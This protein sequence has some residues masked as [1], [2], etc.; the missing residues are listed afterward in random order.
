MVKTR[1]SAER[2]AVQ[3]LLIEDDSATALKV[4]QIL[5]TARG[6][7]VEVDWCE[8]LGDGL[9]QLKDQAYDVILLD[10][11]LPDVDALDVVR[12]LLDA[13]PL[14]PV[15]VLSGEG[16]GD[17]ALQA[18]RH[19]ALDYIP[20]DR[21]DRVRLG[22]AIRHAIEHRRADATLRRQEARLAEVFAQLPQGIVVVDPGGRLRFANPL[23]QEYLAGLTPERVHE[24]D[25]L[26]A[27]GGMSLGD[28][29]G[30]VDDRRPPV[31]VGH[32][33]SGPR[34]FEVRAREVMGVPRGQ[35]LLTLREIS[36]DR[37][38]VRSLE[39][40][41]RVAAIGALSPSLD[42]WFFPFRGLIGP[43]VW[44]I[45]CFICY[46]VI[47]ALVVRTV[48]GLELRD[49]GLRWES[50]GGSI[51]LFALLYVPLAVIVIVV[52]QTPAFQMMYPFYR[53]PIG[54]GDASVWALLYALQ[55]FA[56]EFFFRGFLCH[57]VRDVLGRHTIVLMTVPYVMIHFPKPMF[58]ALGAM[59][60]GL[61]LGF[62][63][64]RTRS[65][66]LGV[67][68]HVAVAWTMDVA[69]LLSR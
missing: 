19:G 40:Q 27:I 30:A 31:V 38:L 18:V 36:E 4:R 58:E 28:I 8:R 21:T 57:G 26:T 68:L 52:A 9:E 32:G 61:V 66:A 45:G 15:V 41:H 49:F 44:A 65:I 2:L 3:T 60:A 24:G 48:L 42:A 46:F 20:R 69:A 25:S 39:T 53:D 29:L 62:L 63:S 43:A 5:R 1:R 14:T 55:F 6:L 22:M 16:E 35:R 59:A 67:L 11:A 23:A 64:L 51:K 33:W 10:L 17:L 47:P 50:M 54:F 37:D 34:T 12:A 7:D 56:L 13:A